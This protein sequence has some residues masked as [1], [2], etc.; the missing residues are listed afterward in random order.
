M[1]TFDYKQAVFLIIQKHFLCIFL[2]LNERCLATLFDNLFKIITRIYIIYIIYAMHIYTWCL[3]N[4]AWPVSVRWSCIGHE[5]VLITRRSLWLE[6]KFYTGMSL[7]HWFD[8]WL[9]M[10][11]EKGGGCSGGG[12]GGGIT[13]VR[14][15]QSDNK[16]LY[17]QIIS[18][19]CNSSLNFAI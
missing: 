15:Y 14:S 2:C 1:P 5:F 19:P 8:V 3:F 6:A 11:T 9:Q 13:V 18:F 10:A 7:R 4:I 17:S 16:R 12:G